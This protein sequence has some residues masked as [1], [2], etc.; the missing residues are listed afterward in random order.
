MGRCWLGEFRCAKQPCDV[1]RNV[2]QQLI[3]L[4]GDEVALPQLEWLLQDLCREKAHV[5][6]IGSLALH[7]FKR[8]GHDVDDKATKCVPLSFASLMV[9]GSSPDAQAEGE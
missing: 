2:N 6:S 4:A 5:I 9:A 7:Q 3:L 8:N 1:V